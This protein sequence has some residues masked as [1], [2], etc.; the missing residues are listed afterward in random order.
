M[1]GEEDLIDSENTDRGVVPHAEHT[2]GAPEIARVT[3]SK[4]GNTQLNS[5][6]NSVS[7]RQGSSPE[8]GGEC[9]DALNIQIVGAVEEKLSAA[10]ALLDTH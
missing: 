1:R 10:N 9:A 2:Q 8:I 7:R 4:E 5:R 6:D 3:S